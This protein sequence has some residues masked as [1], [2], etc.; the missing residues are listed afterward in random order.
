AKSNVSAASGPAAETGFP[1]RGGKGARCRAVQRIQAI[2][3][4]E[5]DSRRAPAR[6]TG[7]DRA[8]SVDRLRS[9]SSAGR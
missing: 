4:Q 1:N 8:L 3:W 5:E 7:Q 9:E 2:F 6:A